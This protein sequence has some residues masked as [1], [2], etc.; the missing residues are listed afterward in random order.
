MRSRRG[1]SNRLL[2]HLGDPRWQLNIS[3][4]LIYE[5]E[6]VLRRQAAEGAFPL[7]LVEIIVDRFCA[8]GRENSIFFRWRP[9]LADSD[10]EFLLEL[11]VRCRC[12]YLITFDERHLAPALTFGI[13]VVTPREFLKIMEL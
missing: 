13:Q 9:F 7:P 1:D 8:V 12:D 6:E 3:A 2:R 11:A 10:D 5:Y 4:A